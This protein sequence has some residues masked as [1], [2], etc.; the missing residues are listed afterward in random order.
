M[1]LVLDYQKEEFEE[2]YSVECKPLSVMAYQK[3]ARMFSSVMNITQGSE[4][5]LSI[6]G[7]DQM[8]NEL[9]AKTAEEVLPDHCGKID[10]INIQQ[11]GQV[12]PAT[13]E[14]V[15][16]HGA[17]LPTALAILM[18]LFQISSLSSDEETLV[19]K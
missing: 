5:E 14:D 16:S 7:L 6:I 4:E 19:K 17:F 1:L 18:R 15:V 12:R 10:G 13:I 8:S 11:G 2:G 9:L 3:V